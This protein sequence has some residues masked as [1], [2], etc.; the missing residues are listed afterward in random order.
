MVNNDAGNRIIPDDRF[1]RAVFPTK[2]K[3]NF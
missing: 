1:E 2:E 3:S